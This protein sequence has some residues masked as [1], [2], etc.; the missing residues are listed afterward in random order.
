MIDV[1]TAYS[2]NNT[3]SKPPDNI[4]EIGTSLNNCL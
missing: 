2:C 3:Q 4:Q 1:L